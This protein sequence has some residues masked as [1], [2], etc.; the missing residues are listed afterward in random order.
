MQQ[1]ILDWWPI[2]ASTLALVVWLLRI[3]AKVVRNSEELKRVESR[4]IE[5]R[6]EDMGERQH[7]F[8]FVNTTLTGIQQDIKEIL[9]SNATQEK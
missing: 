9:K 2:I 1:L 4:F 5:Q 8:D 6:K 7:Q 3:E